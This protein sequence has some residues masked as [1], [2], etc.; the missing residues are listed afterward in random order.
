MNKTCTKCVESKPLSEFFK[1]TSQ[2]SGLAPHCKACAKAYQVA[3][4]EKNKE[5]LLAGMREKHA[6]NPQPVRDRMAAWVKANPERHDKNRARWIAENPEK[7]AE[8]KRAAAAKYRQANPEKKAAWQGR[9][10]AAKCGA[11]TAWEPEFDRLVEQEAANLAKLREAAS[12][13]KWH[14][15]HTVPLLSEQVCGLHNAY[16]LAVIPASV[17]QRK[18]NLYWPDMPC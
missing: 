6:A 15:D 2:K 7:H 3:Y 5:K 13:F 16:N 9:R 8:I 12:G 18:Y 1:M 14:V 4:Y 11:T 10:R 17:N